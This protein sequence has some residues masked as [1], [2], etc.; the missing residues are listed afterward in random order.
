MAIR[1]AILGLVK[2]NCLGH[3]PITNF[4]FYFSFTLIKFFKQLYLKNL[5]SISRGR[6]TYMFRATDIIFYGCY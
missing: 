3:A 1:P 5:S 4:F 2:A 6:K